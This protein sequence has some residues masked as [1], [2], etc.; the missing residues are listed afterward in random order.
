MKRKTGAVLLT[1]FGLLILLV[2]IHTGLDIC[3]LDVGQG[4]GILIRC[5]A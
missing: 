2:R 4:D 3:M 5:G 1:V